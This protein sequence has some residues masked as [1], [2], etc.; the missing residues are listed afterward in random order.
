M[1]AK[2][3]GYLSLLIAFSL[4]TSCQQELYKSNNKFNIPEKST[5]EPLVQFL[6]EPTN[7]S[8]ILET[9]NLAKAFDYSKIAHKTLWVNQFNEKLNISPTTRVITVHETAGLSTT[10]IDSL[11]KFVSKGGTL[12]VTKAAK[13]ERL[14]YFFGMT[15]DADW[16]TNR[17]AS[18]L[19]FN[20]AL[21][22]GM[23]G[24]GF[25]NKTVHLF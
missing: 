24:R 2:K 1:I 7:Y 14:A 13:D 23:Q 25:D 19:F 5:E 4:L 17:E 18:G 21:F 20:K 8:A 15:P 6:I 9:E 16:S 22:P 3:I 11:L 10:A 12:F